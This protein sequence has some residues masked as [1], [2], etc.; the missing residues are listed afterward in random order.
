M[1]RW[2]AEVVDTYDR[3]AARNTP[4][5]MADGI[6]RPPRD[7]DRIRR[8]G[9]NGRPYIRLVMPDG[10]PMQTFTTYSR[11]TTFIKCVDENEALIRWDQRAILLGFA[12]RAQEFVADT[13]RFQEDKGK[14][15]GVVTRAKE[16]GGALTLAAEGSAMHFLTEC[17]DL[18]QMPAL[19]PE[20]YQPGLMSWIET[21]QYFPIIKVE[22]FMVHDGLKVAGTPDRVVR[23][24]PC[25]NCGRI[26]YILDLKTGRVDLYTELQI[27]M[28][29]GIYAN[30]AYYDVDTGWRT[31]QDDI[32]RCRGIVIKM[33]VESG[34]ITPMWTD[35]Y[36]GYQI[37]VEVAP[38]VHDARKNKGLLVPFAPQVNLF[39][40]IEQALDRDH[41]L[42]IQDKH[43]GVWS[44]AHNRAARARLEEL[45]GKA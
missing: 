7:E 8:H 16:A 3:A 13:V 22:K 24:L 18:N 38:R 35:I 23:Y 11:C 31:A 9:G 34:Q 17:C 26:Y 27:A 12:A 36:T 20:R 4:E 10:T 19:V 42:A 40:L 30:S 33:N 6:E 39:V 44:E 1:S 25:D 21:M 41:I 29:L 32:C 15:N 5:T 2:D 37:A 28:Q 43:R 45:R 14:L